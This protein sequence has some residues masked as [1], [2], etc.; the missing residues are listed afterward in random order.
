M[1]PGK[2]DGLPKKFVKPGCVQCNM[3]GRFASKNDKVG[4]NTSNM[5][6]AEVDEF[7]ANNKVDFEEIDMTVVPEA[8]AFVKDEL[9]Y[10]SAPVMYDPTTGEHFQGFNVDRLTS[11]LKVSA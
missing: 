1:V 5:S 2:I 8:L 3:I 9:G 11:M 4:L 10:M 6:Q 7:L